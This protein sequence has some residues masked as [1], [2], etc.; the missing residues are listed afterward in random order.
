MTDVLDHPETRQGI[1]VRLSGRVASAQS[2]VGAQKYVIVNEDGRGLLVIATTKQPTPP[3]GTRVDLTGTIVWNDAGVSLKQSTTDRWST[4]ALVTA[5]TTNPESL[6]P[7]RIVDL[8]AP[9]QEDAWSFITVEG[10]VSATHAS[11]FEID[12]G[13]TSIRVLVRSR[14]GYR[15]QRLSIGDT[16]SVRGLLDMRTDSPAILPQSAEA[17]QILTRA[18]LKNISTQVPTPVNQP[19]LPVGAAAGTFA[20]SEG[21]RRIHAWRKQREEAAAFKALRQKTGQEIA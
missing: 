8:V 13:D 2:I 3:I 15:V 21:W 7:T 18:P 17:I 20:V 10:K 4:N 6:I 1:R 16:V 9:S 12:V 14:I 19:W 11:S 5:T